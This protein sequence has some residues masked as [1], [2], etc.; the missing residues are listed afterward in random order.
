[1]AIHK[2]HI[3]SFLMAFVILMTLA[4]P[5]MAEE[6]APTPKT[7]TVVSTEFTLTRSQLSPEQKQRLDERLKEVM[8]G[9]ATSNMKIGELREVGELGGD[10]LYIQLVDVQDGSQMRGTNVSSSHTFNFKYKNISGQLKDAFKVKL[11][12]K[13]YKNGADSYI[14]SLSGT[15]TVLD[16][17]FRCEWDEDYG[18]VTEPTYHALYMYAYHGLDSEWY[19]FDALCDTLNDPPIVTFDH[20]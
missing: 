6:F 4:L 19:V 9:T 5:A 2:S 11:T 13:W 10:M 15:Y 14:K 7:D 12:C 18:S 17:S 8:S 3:C 16:S 20:T 1:M